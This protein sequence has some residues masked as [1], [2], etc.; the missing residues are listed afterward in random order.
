MSRFKCIAIRWRKG[1]K[2]DSNYIDTN[3]NE[4]NSYNTKEALKTMTYSERKE[5]CLRKMDKA[6]QLQCIWIDPA[7]YVLFQSPWIH[8]ITHLQIE[9]STKKN[10][11]N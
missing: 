11:E 3:Q 2:V 4:C 9:T 6:T 7:Q 5:A 10:L 8:S 1:Q